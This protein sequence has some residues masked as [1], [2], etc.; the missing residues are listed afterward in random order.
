[1]KDYGFEV[2]KALYIKAT[3]EVLGELQKILHDF[4][5]LGLRLGDYSLT[6]LS[7]IFNAQ[8]TVSQISEI[9]NKREELHNAKDIE[10]LVTTL[11][12]NIRMLVENRF[13]E[14]LFEAIGT[15]ME[16]RNEEN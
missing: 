15:V 9:R 13:D 1:M 8:E 11:P 16:P 4:G 6:S 12:E 14:L 10:E 7:K 5:N 2:T 3:S